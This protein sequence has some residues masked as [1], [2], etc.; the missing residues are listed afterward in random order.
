MT[1]T[2]LS[3][4]ATTT[5]CPV[6]PRSQSAGALTRE[7]FHSAA[8]AEAAAGGAYIVSSGVTLATA[9]LCARI[10]ITSGLAVMAKP[11][12]THSGVTRVT[13]PEP[14]QAWKSA[15][16]S[17]WPSPAFACRRR[18]T[19]RRRVARDP[20]IPERSA[21]DRS[22]TMT[23]CSCPPAELRAG[24]PLALAV[25]VTKAAATASIAMRF[26]DLP[27]SVAGLQIAAVL[28]RRVAARTFDS[29]RY[30]RCRR[31]AGA[32]RR[33]RSRWASRSARGGAP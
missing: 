26:I 14:C 29:A 5:P 16:N 33:L 25:T 19:S 13:T 10:L 21:W 12:I 18:M 24:V 31:G 2:P 1:S 17:R 32:T 3:R 11:L 27:F 6:T 30:A 9:G 8:A 15:A 28:W 22:V 20:W 23:D 4:V 7:T